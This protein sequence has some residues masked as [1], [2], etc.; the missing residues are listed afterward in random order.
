LGSYTNWLGRYNL[1][2]V[3]AEIMAI[4]DIPELSGLDEAGVVQ[5][6][7]ERFPRIGQSIG[8]LK[9]SDGTLNKSS[10]TLGLYISAN[11]KRYGLT[12]HHVAFSGGCNVPGEPI[13]LP[14]N[15]KNTSP[16]LRKAD[17]HVIIMHPSNGDHK[18]TK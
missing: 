18:K 12:C 6:P 15:Q 10:G 16:Y 2:D 4:D 1:A 13:N 17:G 3:H 11:G 8:T 9:R 5:A 7:Y 14:D